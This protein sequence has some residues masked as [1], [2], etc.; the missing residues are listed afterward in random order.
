[1]NFYYPI[2]FNN[3]SQFG[4]T[5]VWLSIEEFIKLLIEIQLS[6]TRFT[7]N[8][9]PDVLKI[10]VKFDR[11]VSDN[12]LQSPDKHVTD[13]WWKFNHNYKFD[14]K[15]LKIL[16]NVSKNNLRVISK[17]INLIKKLFYNG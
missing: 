9:L 2:V 4:V 13:F 11:L 5:I 17:S 12:L 8:L 15:V 14:E 16:L 10:E 6:F 7:T 3:N 1:M